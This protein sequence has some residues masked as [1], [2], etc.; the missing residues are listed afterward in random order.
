MQIHAF[1]AL[2]Y[3]H[4][5]L[6]VQISILVL[7]VL[8]DTNLCQITLVHNVSRV[9]PIYSQ[10]KHANPVLKIVKPVAMIHNNAQ[11]NVIIII[12]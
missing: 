1:Y 9:I 8:M 7:F 3:S 10:V 6:N 4:T 2:Q 12:I 5:V 11:V